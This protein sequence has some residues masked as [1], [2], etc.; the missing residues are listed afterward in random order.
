[1][2]QSECHPAKIDGSPGTWVRLAQLRDSSALT[3][4]PRTSSAHTWVKGLSTQSFG[5][6]TVTMASTT[7]KAFNDTTNERGTNRPAHM[8]V[9]DERP[10]P[11]R[12]GP[13]VGRW[14]PGTSE[15]PGRERRR[16]G[17]GAFPWLS[18]H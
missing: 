3:T 2:S 7:A 5:F 8:P 11:M 17:D 6:C 14:S 1:M 4:Q 18:L 15:W 13:R 10:L 9:R 16:G 12:D